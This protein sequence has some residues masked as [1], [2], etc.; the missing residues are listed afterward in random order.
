VTKEKKILLISSDPDMLS[1]FQEFA[2]KGYRVMETARIDDAPLFSL[3]EEWE[4]D[5]ILIDAI[6]PNLLD[7]LT[8]CFKIRNTFPT[9]IMMFSVYDAPLGSIRQ[10]DI[11]KDGHLSDPIN[12]D[13]ALKIIENTFFR[14]EFFLNHPQINN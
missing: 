2:E 11:Y 8:L 10:I 9:P 12:L 5:I 3:I 14:G 1:F 7:S 6:M 13:E 4:F